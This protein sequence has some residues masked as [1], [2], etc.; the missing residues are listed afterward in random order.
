M[1]TYF[2][3]GQATGGNMAHAHCMLEHK[4]T[5]TH[6]QYAI[7]IVCPLQQWVYEG[8]TLLSYTYSTLAVLFNLQ[9]KM[10]RLKYLVLIF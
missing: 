2:R 7:L 6:S 5:N 4:A 9:H 10:C 1:E 3:T 8:A